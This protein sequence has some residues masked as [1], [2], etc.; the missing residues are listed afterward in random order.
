M[1]IIFV[2]ERGGV[3][4]SDAFSERWGRSGVGYFMP[5]AGIYHE[6]GEST[7]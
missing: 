3:A 4:W 7:A 2:E 1:Q 6:W 5:E